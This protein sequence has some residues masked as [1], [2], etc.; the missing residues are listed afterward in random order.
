MPIPCSIA[1]REY[2]KFVECPQGSDQTAVRAK[3]CQEDPIEVSEVE[4]GEVTFEYQ[5]GPIASK[6]SSNIINF[7]VPAGKVVELEKIDAGGDGFALYTVSVNGSTTHKK[8]TYYNSGFDTLFEFKSKKIMASDDIKLNITNRS[9][10]SCDFN[11]TL[12]YRIYDE[13]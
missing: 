13:S 12:T 10:E 6:A 7:I 1:Q 3:I 11:A 4:K 9:G 5:E 8:R 2:E